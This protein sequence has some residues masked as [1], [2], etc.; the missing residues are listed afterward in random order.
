VPVFLHF[1]PKNIAGMGLFYRVEELDDR[2]EHMFY[3]GDGNMRSSLKFL[4]PFFDSIEKR[5]PQKE[6]NSFCGILA[7]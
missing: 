6:C 7:L 1:W 2:T 3:W 4:N 5:M